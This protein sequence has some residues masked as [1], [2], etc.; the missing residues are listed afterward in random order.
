M[1]EQPDHTRLKVQDHN[2]ATPAITGDNSTTTTGTIPTEHSSKATKKAPRARRKLCLDDIVEQL[3]AQQNDGEVRTGGL[4]DTFIFG[5]TPKKR[6]PKFETKEGASVEERKQRKKVA[7]RV[8]KPTKA[9]KQSE[10]KL[11][12][13]QGTESAAQTERPEKKPK[14]VASKDIPTS[15]TGLGGMIELLN[16]NRVD[17]GSDD[18]GNLLPATDVVLEEA[19][20]NEPKSAK[21]A[22]TKPASKRAKK[23]SIDEVVTAVES[24]NTAASDK[25]AKR[26]RR[27]AAIS[28]TEKVAMGYEDELIPVDK[29]RRAPDVESKPRKSRKG[30]VLVSSA[31][32]LS[33]PP[34]TAQVDLVIKD[35]QD[36]DRN[37]SPSSP[38][39][40]VKRGRKPGLK[41]AKGHACVPEEQLEVVEPQ[42]ITNYHEEPPH[43]P[44][45]PAKRGRKAGVKAAKERS[46]VA[47]EKQE[48]IQPQPAEQMSST[49]D[50]SHASDNEQPPLSKLPAKR[51]RKPG[52]KNRKT[53]A[54]TN[55][56]K[57]TGAP[58]A[59][60][61]ASH[62]LS[63]AQNTDYATADE[64]TPAPKIPAKRGRKPGSKNR[65]ATTTSVEPPVEPIVTKLVPKEK[66]STT[67][68][69]KQSIDTSSES[70]ATRTTH[71]VSQGRIGRLQETSADGRS[72]EPSKEATER[73]RPLAKQSSRE[74]SRNTMEEQSTK[75]RR[76]LADFDGNIVRKSLTVDGKKLV[77]SAIDSASVSKIQKSNLSKKVK[78]L[79]APSDTRIDTIR[80]DKAQ[81]TLR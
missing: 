11:E 64:P 1:E 77:P 48:V 61:P 58:A 18:S 80:A 65:K 69:L 51:G 25:P 28:A 2:H 33:S 40:V 37:A 54:A 34:L 8:K 49:K 14:A 68:R 62:H 30:D 38:A 10:N 24:I 79:A 53:V 27:Q 45:V 16:D 59:T 41:T 46:C 6:Q 78:E 26:P 4:E 21:P 5:Y 32:A 22:K 71:S 74:S 50:D 17:R 76:A 52:S 57:S 39:V 73:S 36:C 72:T 56:E 81:S 19:V 31:N 63:P 29:L 60:E 66:T 23:R 47:D 9:K 67:T 55:H 43:S 70:Q 35:I 75:P 15:V 7:P 42:P 3:E 20:K 12:A 13:D 44:K